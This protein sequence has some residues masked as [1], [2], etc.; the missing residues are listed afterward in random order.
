[1]FWPTILFGADATFIDIV[2]R[3]GPI[4]ALL[5]I[6]LYGGFKKNPW[7]VFG[8]VYRDMENRCQ[9]TADEKNDW[10]DIALAGSHIAN[11]LAEREK[12]RGNRR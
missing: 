1:M 9:A 11:T 12:E 3:G 6:I 7:W 2:T 4:A 10:R 8:W 5:G